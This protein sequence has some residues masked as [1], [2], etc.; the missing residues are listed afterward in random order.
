MP[1]SRTLPIARPATAA[2]QHA[3]V[4]VMPRVVLHARIS[5]R[6]LPCADSRENAVA[7]T[8]ALTWKWFVGLVR[9]GR[10]PEE[11]VSAI[12]AYAARAVK[13]GRRLCGQERTRDVLSPLAPGRCCV[14]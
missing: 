5:F 3:F 13:S 14:R 2:V 12:A 4:A 10:R 8:V 7:E 11:F 6:R 1:D 9:Q